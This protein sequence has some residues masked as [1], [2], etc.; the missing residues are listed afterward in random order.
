MS[1]YGR[2]REDE[3]PHGRRAGD[4][5]TGVRVTLLTWN[6]RWGSVLSLVSGIGVML[7]SAGLVGLAIFVY[8]NENNR[9]LM[10]SRAARQAHVNCVR[11]RQFAPAIAAA[12][13][14]MHALTPAQ[15]RAYVATIPKSC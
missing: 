7:I 14:R 12:L 8:A 15:G 6:A 13:L 4:Q 10:N 2:R 5:H 1:D 9:R 3:V 11:T